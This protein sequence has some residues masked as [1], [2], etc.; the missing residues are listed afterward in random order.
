MARKTIFVSDFSGKEI[1]DEKQSATVTVR[2]ADG[3]RGV[4]VAD[5]HVDE[6]IVKR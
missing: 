1:V 6:A 4:V 3:R 5:A 2:Y